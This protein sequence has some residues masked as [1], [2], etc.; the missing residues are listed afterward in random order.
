MYSNKELGKRLQEMREL[1]KVTQEEMGKAVGHT[2]NYISALEHGSNKMS[3]IT[4][5]KYADKLDMSVDELLGINGK[6][7]AILPELMEAIKR[8]SPAEQQ[9]LLKMI[10]L[11]QE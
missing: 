11:I 1:H 8:M 4:L 9:K 7:S 5:I 3:A 6:D 2:K 10:K